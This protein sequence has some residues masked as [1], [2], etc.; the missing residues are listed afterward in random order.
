MSPITLD[1][2]TVLMPVPLRWA[3]RVA[4]LLAELQSSP[5]SAGE[6]RDEE[7]VEDPER[8]PWTQAMI[9]KLAD[10][11]SYEAVLV[12]LD[13]CSQAPGAWITKADI[14]EEAGVSPIQLRNELGALT[15]LINREF[16]PDDWPFEYKKDRGIWYYRMNDPVAQWWIDARAEA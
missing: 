13:R 9:I 5:M 2:D 15:K 7:S 6:G 1:S 8:V 14:E 12:L 10:R 16:E 11:A 3:P 4:Q